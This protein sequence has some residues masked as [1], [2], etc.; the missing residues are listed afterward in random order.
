MI[1]LTGMEEGRDA[2]LKL[3]RGHWEGCETSP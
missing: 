3:L 1:R 2:W